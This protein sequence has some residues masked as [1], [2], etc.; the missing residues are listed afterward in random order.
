[1]TQTVMSIKTDQRRLR[2]RNLFEVEI[3]SKGRVEGFG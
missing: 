1:M 3:K 2:T